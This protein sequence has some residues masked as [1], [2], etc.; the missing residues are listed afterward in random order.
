MDLIPQH[1]HQDKPIYYASE[2]ATA[3]QYTGTKPTAPNVQIVIGVATIIHGT[4][5][6]IKLRI[7]LGRKLGELA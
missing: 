1:L 7:D 2:S 3:G 6:Q 5:G 4:Q